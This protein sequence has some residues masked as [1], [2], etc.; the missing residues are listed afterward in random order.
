VDPSGYADSP[1][2]YAGF[3]NDPVNNRDPTGACVWEADERAVSECWKRVEDYG[4]KKARERYEALV[5]RVVSERPRRLKGD[6]VWYSEAAPLFVIYSM[7][8]GIMVTDPELKKQSINI[9]KD[10]LHRYFVE[11]FA[12]T[13]F[14][15]ARTTKASGKI[16][17]TAEEWEQEKDKTLPELALNA[18][19]NLRETTDLTESLLGRDVNRYFW[20]RAR[21]V[22]ARGIWFYRWLKLLRG[23]KA[24]TNP[25]FPYAAE[26]GD[27]FL[28]L[29]L[30]HRDL[31]GD[32]AIVPAASASP[33]TCVEEIRE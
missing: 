13:S 11:L 28:Q 30:Q 12:R 26:G 2:L 33:D 25:R 6:D 24:R 32:E 27:Y 4:I 20:G 22:R 16:G 23:E 15:Q 18:I 1:N 17:M 8:S 31:C 29:G 21:P 14:D 9:E 19:S 10:E 7:R 5:T 3:A